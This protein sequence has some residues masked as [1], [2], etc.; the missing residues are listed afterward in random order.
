MTVSGVKGMHSV[1][2]TGGLKSRKKCSQTNRLTG[3]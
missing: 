2:G 1:S 3:Y